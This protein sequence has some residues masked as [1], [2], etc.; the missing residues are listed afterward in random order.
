MKL[1]VSENAD[2]YKMAVL[3]E[4]ENGMGF[5]GE[6]VNSDDSITNLVFFTP[7]PIG[8]VSP[9][10]T[11]N[12]ENEDNGSGPRAN[13]SL[14]LGGTVAGA[15]CA[16]ILVGFFTGRKMMKKKED[17]EVDDA[18]GPDVEAVNLND[19]S[20]DANN[21]SGLHSILNSSGSVTVSSSFAT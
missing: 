13:G 12:S 10:G 11:Q 19:P 16:F 18:D 4:I 2:T 21:Q 14:S 20:F 5:N 7:A 3:N 9:P 8:P 6:L 1:Y 15:V 17:G